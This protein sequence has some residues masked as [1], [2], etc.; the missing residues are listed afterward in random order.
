MNRGIKGQ[1]ARQGNRKSEAAEEPAA[2]IPNDT[3]EGLQE[4]RF[5]IRTVPGFAE[6]ADTKATQSL[7]GAITGDPM[8][9]LTSELDALKFIPSSVRFGRGK[10]RGRGRGRGGFSTS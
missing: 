1:S 3:M 8:E 10:G 6:K 2:E 7:Q 5:E 9:G 4:K